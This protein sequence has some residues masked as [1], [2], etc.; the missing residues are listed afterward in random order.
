MDRTIGEIRRREQAS[1]PIL[2]ALRNRWLGAQKE[3][4]VAIPPALLAQIEQIKDAVE[5]TFD[6]LL[7]LQLHGF[8]LNEDGPMITTPLFYTSCPKF[9][10]AIPYTCMEDDEP[11]EVRDTTVFHARTD[12]LLRSANTSTMRV[13]SGEM[14]VIV[15]GDN[16][17]HVEGDGRHI[18]LSK[19]A[20]TI[21]QPTSSLDYILPIGVIASN[22]SSSEYN[23]N[24]KRVG[25]GLVAWQPLSVQ[26]QRGAL[27]VRITWLDIDSA[28]V[29]Y[30]PPLQ[31]GKRLNTILLR[32][33]DQLI[34]LDQAC[35]RIEAI[36]W[37]GVVMIDRAS[38]HRLTDE[39]DVVLNATKGK[40]IDVDELCKKSGLVRRLDEEHKMWCE[41]AEKWRKTYSK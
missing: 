27:P 30:V 26:A 1:K 8:L 40:N 32:E 22:S 36:M 18:I 31:A 34:K 19:C 11:Y 29:R 5:N 25:N 20:I 15:P 23:E 9:D 41:I 3:T 13:Q 33:I 16:K 35:R 4:D 24:V 6:L 17:I 37:R 21:I 10:H 38:L 39:S 28:N 7:L 14:L 2:Q 12:M